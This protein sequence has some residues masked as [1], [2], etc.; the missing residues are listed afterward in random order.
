[1]GFI[2]KA[3][4]RH[5]KL[6]V[7]V[8]VY[9]IA[10]I[11]RLVYLIELQSIP[12]F[13][14]PIM[15]EGYHVELVKQVNSPGGLPDEPYFRAPLYIYFLALIFEL[16]GGSFFWIRFIQILIGSLL[17]VL[18][19]L[20]GLRLFKKTIAYTAAFITAFYPTFIYYDNSLL[21]TFMM[22]LLTVLLVLQL[23]RC[24]E[25]PSGSNFL[26]AGLILGLAAITRPN[27]LLLAPALLIW[28]WIILKPK[29]SLKK[30][31]F[32]Y[33]LLGLIC[34]VVI[35]P[36]TIRNYFVSGDFV[37]IAWQGGYNF[38]LGNNNNAT[39]WSATV[40]GI[41]PSWQGSYQE[42]ITIAE[43][44]AGR[45]LRHSEVS[46]YWFSEGLKEI[47]RAPRHFIELLF[48]KLRF[49]ING[50][51]IPNNQ[52]LYSVRYFVP[53]IKPLMFDHIIFFPFGILAPL[54]IIGIGLS[55]NQWRKYLL[56]YLLLGSYLISL[57][58]FFVCARFR[59]PLIPLLIL[60][61]VFGI[62]HL[63]DRFKK[64]DF[65]VLIPSILI[66]AALLLESNHF[67]LGPN[68][69]LFAGHSHYFIGSGYLTKYKL[70][71]GKL[72][73]GPL[74]GT[75]PDILERSQYHFKKA[76]EYDTTHALAY[77]DLATIEMLSA[78]WKDAK[79]LLEKAMQVDPT[80]YQPYFNYSRIHEI[81]GEYESALDLLDRIE[82]R[83]QYNEVVF[84]N[85]GLAYWRL[86]NPDKAKNALE[87]C[88]RINPKNNE[89][90]RI[91]IRMK[92]E[93]RNRSY[94]P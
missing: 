62:F 74:T 51:E 23:Y 35:L 30:A 13:D 81:N 27:I 50:Y 31:I 65:K 89:A 48:R 26:I 38:Y 76:L 36:V 85:L 69:N 67:I 54:A 63:V 72:Q 64:R 29:L 25:K 37:F 12:F 71:P 92:Q 84:Y 10:L 22:V 14:N 53:V 86:G 82:Q 90:R 28:V 16:T 6:T 4:S 70:G 19:M 40:F 20:L 79:K 47:S 43:K 61:A 87:E 41:D 73:T 21:I 83:F 77:N 2:P 88:L 56:I 3:F 44:N 57:L 55:L 49:F 5:E 58:L 80:R 59:Q 9:F 45:S 1:M 60:F 15:D 42:S 94:K 24:Q 11:I 91:Y 66:L 39:G 46:D 68:K 93:L 18:V 33:V 75:L 32:K 34:I 7:A 78:H 17:P 52:Q 8:I